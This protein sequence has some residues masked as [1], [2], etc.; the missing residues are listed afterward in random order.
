M[1]VPALEQVNRPT[2]RDD[3]TRFPASIEKEL[4]AIF[5]QHYDAPEKY[6][7]FGC[8]GD[9]AYDIQDKY[10]LSMVALLRTIDV[11]Y[12]SKAH[13]CLRKMYGR[14]APLPL[15]CRSSIEAM[16][17]VCKSSYYR[18]QISLVSL[19]RRCRYPR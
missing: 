1:V 9:E 11:W 2:P 13:L 5:H 7:L 14:G 8:T 17:K 10:A 3:L 6:L 12:V 18:R 4:N 16:W 19:V 15:L